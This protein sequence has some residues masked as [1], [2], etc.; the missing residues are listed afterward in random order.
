[1]LEHADDRHA[2]AVGAMWLSASAW[3]YAF[4]AIHILSNALA[5][6]Q[7]RQAEHLIKLDVHHLMRRRL[8][9]DALIEAGEAAIVQMAPRLLGR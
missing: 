1:M 6:E 9:V 8:D 5:R 2:G 7:T 4:Q 3:D